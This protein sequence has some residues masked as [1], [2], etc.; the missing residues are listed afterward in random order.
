M[1]AEGGRMGGSL[2]TR[3]TGFVELFTSL[4]RDRSHLESCRNDWFG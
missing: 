1:A 4:V 2:A 3:S